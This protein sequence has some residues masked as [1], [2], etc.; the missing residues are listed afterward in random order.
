MTTEPSGRLIA[1]ISDAIRSVMTYCPALADSRASVSSRAR[2]GSASPI[3][4]RGMAMVRPTTS[5][6]VTNAA[7][8]RCPSERSPA[9]RTA[10]HR[11]AAASRPRGTAAIWNRIHPKDMPNRKVSS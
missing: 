4:A 3:H 1:S 11:Q 7:G 2:R 6:S 10:P 9:D 8:R 5:R